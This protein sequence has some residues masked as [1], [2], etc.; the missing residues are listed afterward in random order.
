MPLEKDEEFREQLPKFLRIAA[1]FRKDELD[2]L[3]DEGYVDYQTMMAF[4]EGL[5]EYY[6]DIADEYEE[7][8][9]CDATVPP[10]ECC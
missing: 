8:P 3:Y 10:A 1:D 7:K 6:L 4:T 9:R 2:D 5:K